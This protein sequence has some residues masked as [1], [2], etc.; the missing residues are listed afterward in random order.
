[1]RHFRIL[2]FFAVIATLCWSCK[3]KLDVNAEWKDITVVYGLL[4][5]TDSIHYIK[6][7]KAFLGEGDAMAFAKISDSSNYPDKMEVTISEYFVNASKDSVLNKVFP[8][9]TMTIHDKQK[10]DSIF[11]YPDQLMYYFTGNIEHAKDS[12]FF[13]KLNIRIKSTNKQVRSQSV[14]VDDKFSITKPPSNIP[15][16][17]VNF[18]PGVK[19]QLQ[20]T[21]AK[22]GRRY[23]AVL[24]MLYLETS[25]ADPTKQDSTWI[26][27][28]LFTNKQTDDVKGGK[29]MEE[30]FLNDGFYSMMHAQIPVNPSV[31]R[32]V[33]KIEYIF[34]VGSDDLNTY[35]EVTEP[36]TS[37]V[38]E[39]PTFSNIDNGIG[40][41]AS[42]TNRTV[43][44]FRLGQETV[45]Q[46]QTNPLTKDLGF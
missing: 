11:Y 26:S 37:I 44:P 17:K 33:R 13:Y 27:W 14:L 6:I 1:M 21:S 35:M 2:L 7:T 29:T 5:Q 3:A 16:F 32:A 4:D 20:W 36:S 19:T 46:I 12:G 38:Q 24:R 42:R 43:G 34:T 39:R 31:T 8:C 40:L 18:L 25:K 23:Q 30:Y 28:V 41:F 10:G 22:N 15:N 45:T 9:D